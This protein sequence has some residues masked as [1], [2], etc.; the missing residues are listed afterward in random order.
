MSETNKIY[1]VSI[2][3]TS[4]FIKGSAAVTITQAT[5]TALTAGPSVN[6]AAHD[7]AASVTFDGAAELYELIS[8]A[9]F[10][11]DNGGTISSVNIPWNS[12]TVTVDVSFAANASASPKT[13]TVSA[14]EGSTKLQGSA[15]A[16]ITQATR[17]DL[18]AGQPVDAAAYDAR[19]KVTFTGAIGLTLSAADFA[20]DNGGTISG[21][22]VSDDTATVSVRPVVNTST[23]STKT[24]TVSIAAGSTK[25]KGGATVVITQSAAP[26]FLTAAIIEN[27]GNL[28]AYITNYCSGRTAENPLTIK[29]SGEVSSSHLVTVREAVHTAD[30]YVIWELSEITGSLTDTQIGD[31]IDADGDTGRDKIK[32]L[33]LP[34]GMTSISASAFSWCGYLSSVTLPAGLTT[35]GATAFRDCGSLTSVILP[36]SLTSI[37]NGAF[38]DCFNLP[39]ITLP[40]GLT[41]IEYD[42]FAACTYLQTVVFE[43]SNVEITHIAAFP[44]QT[45]LPGA[46]LKNVYESGKQGDDKGVAGVYWRSLAGQTSG[47]WYRQ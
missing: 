24:Y 3:N 22:E 38:G 37:Y 20:V 9:D 14:A 28:S 8:A 10:A 44:Y 6:A 4:T 5:R 43:G 32:G 12:D 19:A 25:I 7:T 30:T 23:S 18:T 13:Y 33:V 27:P 2:V 34:S 40:E 16:A 17:I 46:A 36:S 26:P 21:V 15:A 41:F 1:T 45:T 42:A 11:V 39:E 35:I 47:I 31:T 29:F